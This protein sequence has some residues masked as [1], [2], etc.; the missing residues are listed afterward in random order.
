[1]SRKIGVCKY[2]IENQLSD[3]GRIGFSVIPTSNASSK[4]LALLS[5]DIRNIY[6]ISNLLQGNIVVLRWP[7]NTT[8]PY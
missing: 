7:T 3:T 4:I 5:K 6:F 2:W 1:M 8:V